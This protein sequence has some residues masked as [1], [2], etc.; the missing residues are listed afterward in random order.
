MLFRPN[1]ALFSIVF[2]LRMDRF[3]S[4]G[5]N[6]FGQLSYSTHIAQQMFTRCVDVYPTEFTQRITVL[7]SSS[8]IYFGPHHAG[9]APRQWLLI[10][11][12]NSAKGSQS[13][14]NRN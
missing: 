11:F 5:Y 9:T 2:Y 10:I 8:L 13:S 7:S 4:V 12:T 14:S 1:E 6:I 3:R